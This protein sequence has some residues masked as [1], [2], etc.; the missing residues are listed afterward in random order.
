MT[1]GSLDGIVGSES[2]FNRCLYRYRPPRPLEESYADLRGIEAGIIR[3][4]AEVTDAW[5][6]SEPDRG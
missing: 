2:N 5:T 1:S 6:A 4:L 3:M